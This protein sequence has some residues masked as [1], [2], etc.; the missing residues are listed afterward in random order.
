MTRERDIRLDILRTIAITFVIAIH[1]FSWIGFYE[2]PLNGWIFLAL[3]MVRV[4]FVTCVPLF[5][6]LSGYFGGGV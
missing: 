4:C 3:S 6:I 1:A 5:L 2:Q